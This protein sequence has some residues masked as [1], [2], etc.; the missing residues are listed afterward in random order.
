MAFLS[1]LMSQGHPL[2]QIAPAMVSLGDNGTLAQLY[3]SL[4][5]DAQ[6]NAW[7]AF[8]AAVQALPGGVTNDDPFGGAAQPTQIA[9][10]TPLTAAIAGRVFA[11]ILGNVAAGKAAN[12]IVADVRALLVAAP[13]A[14]AA[15]ASLCYPKSRRLFPPD[16]AA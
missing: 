14:K 9:H 16:K 1:W 15:A 8:Q 6:E 13:A 4:T 3:A 11:S 10:I 5:A 2:G 12:Q 7:P